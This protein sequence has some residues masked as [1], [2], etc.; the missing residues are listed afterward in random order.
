MS[1]RV[2]NSFAQLPLKH[3]SYFAEFDKV[4]FTICFLID[5]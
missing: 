5:L 2:C 3:L 4:E 1:L